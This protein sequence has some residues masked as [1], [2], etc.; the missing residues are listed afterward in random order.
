MIVKVGFS[1]GK[2][3]PVSAV[4]RWATR[5]KVSHAYLIVDDPTLGDELILEAD[6]GGFQFCRYLTFKKSNNVIAEVPVD[7]SAAA[8]QQADQWVGEVGYDYEGLVG[9]AIVKL[10]L[11]FKRKISNPMHDPRSMFCSEAMTR[12]LQIAKYPGADTLVPQDTS[13][14]AL[15][16]FLENADL[17]AAA[18]R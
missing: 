1:T 6:R 3:S 9:E 11:W 15:L 13:P 17:A 12:L 16:E 2:R 14:E 18:I 5:S 4:I 10:A 7:L 8:V